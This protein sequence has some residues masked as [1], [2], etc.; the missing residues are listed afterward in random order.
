MLTLPT[1]SGSLET[2]SLV[3]EPLVA[4]APDTA[5]TRTAFAASHVVSD[6]MR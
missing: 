1:P 2:Y 6:P 3:G 5:L 4:R